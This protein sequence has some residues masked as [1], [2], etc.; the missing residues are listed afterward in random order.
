[1]FS[2]TH[3]RYS[4]RGPRSEP[5]ATVLDHTSA[6]HILYTNL[7]SDMADSTNISSMHEQTITI[8]TIPYYTLLE[9]PPNSPTIILIHALMANH[10]IYDS[11]VPILHKAGYQTLRYDHIGHNNTPPPTDPNRNKQGEFTFDDFCHHLNRIWTT[12][13]STRDHTPAAIIGCSIGG[14]LAIRYHMLY[15]PPPGTTTKIISMAAPG[16]S[17]LPNSPEK[18][19]ARIEQWRIDGTNKQLASQTLERWF[20]DRPPT[21]DMENARGIIESCTLDGYEICA[22]ATMNFD[23][24]D[25]LDQI[26][27]GENVMV[28]AGE[29][30]GNIGPR[31]VLVDVSRRIRGSRYVLLEGV[32]HIPPMH[33]EVFEPVM[34]EFLGQA[35]GSS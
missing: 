26:K 14:V 28:L 6:I 15:P 24:T 21:F 20:P 32:G 17:T 3:S 16:L 33:P 10:H 27:D 12:I 2:L 25:Q 1:M 18:W 13:A 29:K 22:W 4:S 11:T 34:L 9:G 5:F 19:K 30:D 31:E 7:L 8:D 35:G 23:Y